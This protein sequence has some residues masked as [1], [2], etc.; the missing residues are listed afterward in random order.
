MNTVIEVTGLTKQYHLEH[1]AEPFTALNDVSFTVNKGDV[2]GIIGNNGSGKSTLL[3][4]LSQI[5]RPSSGV[6]K[7]YGS[8]TSILEVGTNF[9]PDLTGH[10]NVKLHLHLSGLKKD[11]FE[12]QLNHIKDFSEIG[13]FFYQP[14]KV[15]SSGMFLRLAFS[16]AFH[17]HSDVLLLDEV[18]SV[19]DEGFRLKC[20]DMLKQLAAS[21][22]TILFVSHNRLEILDLST[23]CIWLNNGSIKRIGN[24]AS[25]LSE[26]FAMHRDNYDGKKQIIETH[27]PE[28]SNTEND[29][30]TVDIRWSDDKAPGNDVMTIRELA[31]QPLN[32]GGKLLNSEPILI[33]FV[34][35]KKVAGTQ[36]GAFFFLQDVFYQPVL[37]GHFLNNKAGKDFSHDL[38]DQTGLIEI[39]CIIPPNFLVP[40]KYYLLPRFGM[41]QDEWNIESEEVFRFSEKLHFTVHAS[42]NFNDLI[43]DLSKGSVR[44][45]LDWEISLIKKTK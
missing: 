17:L 39:T 35:N 11:E 5:T 27:Q 7:F 1:S 36:I 6:I 23:K 26:Y 9:H 8:V 21:G 25:V 29:Y 3:K 30:G 37:V 38:K 18:L 4:I 42:A 14:I 31:V 43:G 40:G 41:E 44:P 34:I 12:K 10:E 19:G 24:P 13:D 28:F 20:Q 16:M 22:K 32:G 45:P 2:V 15:Y 33:R